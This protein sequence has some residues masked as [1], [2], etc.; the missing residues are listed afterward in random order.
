MTEQLVQPPFYGRA[1]VQQPCIL[2]DTIVILSSQYWIVSIDRLWAPLT[3]VQARKYLQVHR[4]DEVCARGSKVCY[5]EI[6]GW[7][8]QVL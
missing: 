8:D 5:P 7:Y 2:F 4:K 6:S 3:W 1:L